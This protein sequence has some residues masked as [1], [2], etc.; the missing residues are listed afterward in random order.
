V[1]GSPFPGSL[2][3][4]SVNKKYLFGAG[5]NGKDIY[6]FAITSNGA[7]Q[8]V[9]ETSAQKYNPY[10]CGSIGPTQID[11]SGTTLYNQ[12]NAGDCEDV[13][14]IQAF[15]IENNGELQFIGNSI[16]GIPTDIAS[17]APVRFL[18]T[19]KFAYQTGCADDEGLAGPVNE[20]YKRE[21]NGMLTTVAYDNVLPK[22]E[23]PGDVLQWTPV[24]RQQK[25]GQFT[26][27]C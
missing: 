11:Y 25:W 2:S 14:F 6:T 20:V 5:D 18:G 10:G 24:L 1:P 16:S 4:M 22:T 12:V 17:L 9:S 21:S 26:V 7:L 13:Q 19:N 8:Q 23:N 15:K 3:H 27:C